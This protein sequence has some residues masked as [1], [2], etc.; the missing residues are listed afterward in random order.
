MRP[1]ELAAFL[2]SVLSIPEKLA[3]LTVELRDVR[4]EL[5]ALRATVPPALV[6]AAEAA[7]RTGLSPSTMRRL[8]RDGRVPVVRLGHSVRVDLAALAALGD[9]GED[10]V[11]RLALAAREGQA[12]LRAER[13][14]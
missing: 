13:G 6:S 2:S 9:T 14:K 7:K 8:I 11:A 10:H 12:R 3:L 1:D 5:T 4:A